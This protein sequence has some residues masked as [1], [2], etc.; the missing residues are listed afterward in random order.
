MKTVA[1]NV[2]QYEWGAAS[3]KIPA[4][5]HTMASPSNMYIIASISFLCFQTSDK[6]TLL[7]VDGCSPHIYVC[8]LIL[9]AVF[10]AC[11]FSFCVYVS[12]FVCKC[13]CKCARLQL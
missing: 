10:N 4:H 3:L 8:V 12:E 6:Y 2:R 7:P 13:L 1:S 11:V 9:V 5:S